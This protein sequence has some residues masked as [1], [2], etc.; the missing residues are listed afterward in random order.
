MKKSQVSIIIIILFSLILFISISFYIINK[1]KISRLD[2]ESKQSNNVDYIYLYITQCL[3]NAGKDAFKLL[4]ARGGFLIVPWQ[5]TTLDIENGNFVYLIYD[6][7]VR[8]VQDERTTEAEVSLYAEKKVLDCID[9]ADFKNPGQDIE[10]LDEPLIITHVGE[11]MV[12]LEMDLPIKITNHNGIVTNLEKFGVSLPIR[13]GKI[14]KVV[15][16][17]LNQLFIADLKNEMQVEERISDGL[18]PISPLVSLNFMYY[19]DYPDDINV[20]YYFVRSPVTL[21]RIVDNSSAENYNFVF[22]AIHMIKDI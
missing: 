3:E 8:Y 5:V 17:L 4:G 14:K 18:L 15:D 21:W 6:R 22:A 10:I 11:D 1:I 7:G 9:D 20:D 19:N 2:L 16:K 12:K 13:Y